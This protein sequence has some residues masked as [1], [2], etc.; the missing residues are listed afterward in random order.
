RALL[1]IELDRRMTVL[2]HVPA[3]VHRRHRAV[4]EFEDGVDGGRRVDRDLLPEAWPRGDRALLHRDGGEGSD[5]LHRADQLD[6][7]GD[8]VGPDVEDRPGARLEE[9]IRIRMP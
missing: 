4:L 9:E 7:V 6:K 8:V 3:G 2:P 1:A 5:T